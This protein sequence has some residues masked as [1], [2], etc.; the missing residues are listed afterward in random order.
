MMKWLPCNII[1]TQ[2][3]NAV[4]N[5]LPLFICFEISLIVALESNVVNAHSKEGNFFILDHVAQLMEA[6][7]SWPS[8]THAQG[9]SNKEKPI[10]WLWL[11]ARVELDLIQQISERIKKEKLVKITSSFIIFLQL[12]YKFRSIQLFCSLSILFIF[13]FVTFNWNVVI[14]S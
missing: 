6:F 13:Y 3:I 5:F 2:F 4:R 8:F 10:H 11:W 9:P 14:V 1:I 7:L 12:K